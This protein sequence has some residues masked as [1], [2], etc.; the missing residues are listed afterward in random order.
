M[1]FGDLKGLL[2]CSKY[3]HCAV[4]QSV[5]HSWDK[6][7]VISN[8]LQPLG[9]QPALCP[10]DFPDNTG[11]GCHLLLQGIFW[12]HGLNLG[13]SHYRQNLYHLSHQGNIVQYIDGT[14]YF[15]PVTHPMWRI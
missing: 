13:L 15:N 12:T 11:V 14:Y 9:L 10:W 1:E 4:Y 3:K 6:M 5:N 2:N 8:S 7:L